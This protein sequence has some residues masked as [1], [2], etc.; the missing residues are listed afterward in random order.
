MP[1]DY[2]VRERHTAR[3]ESISLGRERVIE[4][5]L[6]TR[7]E[8]SSE[9]V[10]E[11]MRAARVPSS[12]AT[13]HPQAQ[14]TRGRLPDRDHGHVPNQP[15]IR[16]ILRGTSTSPQGR[17]Q[18]PAR[19]RAPLRYDCA[20]TE[21]GGLHVSF[22]SQD[23]VLSL[24]PPPSETVS[25][26]TEGVSRL[27]RRLRGGDIDRANGQDET[28]PYYHER[29]KDRHHHHEDKEETDVDEK[30]RTKRLARALSESPSRERLRLAAARQAEGVQTQAHGPYRP[31]QPPTESMEVL[32]QSTTSQ[33]GRQRAAT[34]VYDYVEHRR[35]DALD[36]AER[37]VDVREVRDKEG[38]W[39]EVKETVV[40]P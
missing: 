28:K 24:S 5:H 37:F 21:A 38:R 26:V 16:S 3:G 11:A 1:A 8:L 27:R 22:A 4:E 10:A 12:S 6:I 32:P 19:L 36:G 18:S 20:G 35:D 31:D 23:D 15:R 33:R 2:L 40:L 7:K 13:Q 17:Q 39:I 29:P 25:N 14:E 30:Y 9:E 34:D